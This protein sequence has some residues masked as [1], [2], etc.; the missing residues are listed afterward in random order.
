M[1]YSLHAFLIVAIAT[2]GA[3]SA[4]EPA[5]VPSTPPPSE[6]PEQA[7]PENLP[8]PPEAQPTEPPESSAPA[9]VAPTEPPAPPQGVPAGQWVFTSQ[10]GWIWAP[11]DQQYT[12]VP[13]NGEPY[14]FVYY[15]V[16][17]WRWMAAPWVFGWGPRP[18]WG[19]WGVRRFAWYAH[20]WFRAPAYR[21]RS[22]GYGGYRSSS[23]ASGYRGSGGYGGGGRARGG[24]GHGR[25]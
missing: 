20:P 25:R 7:V 14:M 9:Q 2:A 12:A 3:A 16:V 5:G 22:G 15:P 13:T 1:R 17:G 19:S 8:A 18:Y 24:G 21:G 6:P 10:Y 11:Y 23:G 4:Q